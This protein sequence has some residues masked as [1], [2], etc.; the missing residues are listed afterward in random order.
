[1]TIPRI[2]GITGRATAGKDTVANILSEEFGYARYSWADPLKKMA[3]T[4]NPRIWMWRR[5]QHYVD[6]L[7]WDEAKKIPKVRKFLQF[8]GTECVRDCVHPDTW[9]WAG[10]Q[11][12]KYRLN[13]IPDCRFLNEANWVK[14]AGGIL[15]LVRRPGVGSVNNHVSDAGLIDHLADYVIDNDGT[16][17]SLRSKVLGVF[18][19][20]P[21]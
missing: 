14:G 4:L 20:Y 9:V 19:D 7:G 18:D 21:Y 8:V 5:L 6:K 10:G 16:I 12:M 13:V 17:E 11:A 1:M 3:Y 2:V 15:L